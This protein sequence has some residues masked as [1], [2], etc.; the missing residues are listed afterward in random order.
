MAT[1][2][3]STPSDPAWEIA[4]GQKDPKDRGLAVTGGEVDLGKHQ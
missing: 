1:S 4:A 3:A 2:A